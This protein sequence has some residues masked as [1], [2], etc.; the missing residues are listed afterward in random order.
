[1]ENKKY[2]RTKSKTYEVKQKL[3]ADERQGDDNG[4]GTRVRDPTVDIW[5]A[6]FRSSS[7]NYRSSRGLV[8]WPTVYG[9]QRRP[10]LG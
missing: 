9:L 10:D 1:M 8:L 4:R 6:A 5:K 3:V 2:S 7:Q